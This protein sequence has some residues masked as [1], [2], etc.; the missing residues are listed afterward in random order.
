MTRSSTLSPRKR[1]HSRKNEYNKPFNS[2]IIAWVLL[3]VLALF[4]VAVKCFW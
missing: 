4:V 3:A 2:N 1:K